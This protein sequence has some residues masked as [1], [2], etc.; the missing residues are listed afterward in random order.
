[1][2]ALLLCIL[3]GITTS[4][5]VRRSVVAGLTAVL[6]WGYVY[7][8]ARANFLA[9][10]AHFIFDV[11]LLAFYAGYRWTLSDSE[12]A[13]VAPVRKWLI[14]FT[15]WAVVVSLFVLQHPL[16][17]VVGLRGNLF[18]LPL[19]LVAARL[20]KDEWREMAV[21]VSLLNLATFA[22][23]SAEYVFGVQ[24]FFPPNAVTQIIY[25]SND[26]AGYRY[27]RIP[28]SFVTAHA[29]GGTMA[30]TLPLL[31]SALSAAGQTWRR[32]LPVIVGILS[33]MLGVL[34]SSTR[35]N[36]VIA[37]ALVAGVLLAGGLRGKARALLLVSVAVIGL[38][39]VSND[40]VSRFKSLG[41]SAAVT[42]R[43]TGS[44][45]RTF[46]EILL[47]YPLGNGMGGGGTSIPYFLQELIH[48]PV[49]L[50]SEYARILLEQG[51]PGLGL[52]LAFAAT[53]AFASQAF[54]PSPMR[55]GRVVFWLYSCISF[56]TAAIG[57]GMM[58]AIPQT[59]FLMFYAGSI[60]VTPPIDADRNDD[61]ENTDDVPALQ[62]HT[63]TNSIPT[64]RPSAPR[65]SES[66]T[67]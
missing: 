2:V 62:D 9:P 35:L 56:C 16:I 18:F 50:E 41:D 48:K 59:A 28:S 29:Y 46:W 15:A 32:S 19:L 47:D 5:A 60:L 11:S 23:G 3:A 63:L 36:F 7:G 37:A 13:L 8:I 66:V 10:L 17:E 64:L 49:A 30:A 21:S 26:V 54:R 22:L 53:V 51:I 14:L 45:N 67:R 27:L 25:N 43:I 38:F 31:F 55:P 39:A 6:A 40:R 44:V 4:W 20:S 34:L 58:T 65:P 12:R 52:W 1:M 24:R 33:A 61:E 57:T 42:T